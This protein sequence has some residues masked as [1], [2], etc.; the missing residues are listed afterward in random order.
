MTA[1]DIMTAITNAHTEHRYSRFGIR[2]GRVAQIG[3]E[4]ECS[5]DWDFENDCFSDNLLPGTSSTGIG[6]LWFD[7]ESDD[8]ETIETALAKHFAN[9]YVGEMTY[10]IAGHDSV[11]GDDFGEEIICNATIICIIK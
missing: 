10:V 5:H 2:T 11:Y 8:V 4:L 7:G 6:Y 3:E 1:I 9:N